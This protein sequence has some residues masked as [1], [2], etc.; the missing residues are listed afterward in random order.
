M[1][2]CV[3]SI[4]LVGTIAESFRALYV[5]SC[6]LIIFPFGVLLIGMTIRISKMPFDGIDQLLAGALVILL[7]QIIV[8]YLLAREIRKLTILNRGINY[9]MCHIEDGSEVQLCEAVQQE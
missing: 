8:S 3:F 1:N 9:K 5:Y 6:L 7:M 2:I 4:G